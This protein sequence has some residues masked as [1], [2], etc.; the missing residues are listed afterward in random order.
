MGNQNVNLI[1]ETIGRKHEWIISFP[2]VSGILTQY[3]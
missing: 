1:L 3:W 2:G